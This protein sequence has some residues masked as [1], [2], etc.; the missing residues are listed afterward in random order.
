M[1]IRLSCLKGRHV[2]SPNEDAPIEISN[3]H[4][5][6]PDIIVTP[7]TPTG[8]LSSRSAGQQSESD[9]DENLCC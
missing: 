9:T 6:V 4:L 1:G 5:K 8:T 3:I 2:C 7:P